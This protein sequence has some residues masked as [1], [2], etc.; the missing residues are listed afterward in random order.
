[1]GDGDIRLMDGI[2]NSSGRVEVDIGGT[3][4]AVCA[5]DFDS[6]EAE[7]VCRQ[8]GLSLHNPLA[9]HGPAPNAPPYDE[10]MDYTF[11]SGSLPDV[12]YGDFNCS[13]SEEKLVNCTGG[14]S[15][16]WNTT[17]LNINCAT[18]DTAGVWC[19]QGK[20]LLFSF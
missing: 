13:G 9:I 19:R 15:A 7:V 11:P 18:Y 6:E 16:S 20:S 10:L 14:A 8:L 1:M 12:W 3:W 5:A 4:H 17:A 2:N